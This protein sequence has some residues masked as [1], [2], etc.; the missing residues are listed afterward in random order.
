M[1]QTLRNNTKIIVIIVVVAFII[2]SAFVGFGGMFGGS[3]ANPQSG[4]TSNSIARVNGEDITQREFMNVLRSQASQTSNLSSSQLIDFR[5]RVLNFIIERKLLLQN[6]AEQGIEVEITDKDVQ[7]E[8]DNILKQY[9]MSQSDLESNLKKQGYSLDEF[10][11][12]LK[13][14]L[15]EQEK[16]KKTREQTYEQVKVTEEEI[17]QRY[18]KNNK[19]KKA[20]GKEYEKAK[21]EIKKKLLEEQQSQAFNSWLE[22]KKAQAE[23]TIFDPVLSSAKAFDSQNYEEAIS[24]FT[25]LIKGDDSSPGAGVYIY[26][27]RAYQQKGDTEKAIETYE[28]AIK[29]YPNN[30]ETHLNLGDI[31]QSKE[32]KDKAIKQYDKAAELVGNNYMAHV[33]LYRSYNKVGAKE[34][35]QKEMDAIKKIQQDM[36][37]QQQQL[38]Q[39][40]QDQSQNKDDSNSQSTTDSENK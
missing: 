37:K 31:Y 18:E 32:K 28:K 19:D 23:I 27:A 6:A 1:F 13:T 26:L 21:P 4:G 12:Q 39:K 11:Q 17:K 30:W 5:L 2:T 29:A 3:S 35:A 36:M 22:N 34:K 8:I 40:Q 15:R 25:N 9:Q 7:N 24:G 20:S 33:Q 10:K 38:Q 16:I 14:D